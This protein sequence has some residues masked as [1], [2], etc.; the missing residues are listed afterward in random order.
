MGR[1]GGGGGRGCRVDGGGVGV[2]T[3]ML[4]ILML[5]Y[6]NTGLYFSLTFGYTTFN[7]KFFYIGQE[8]YRKEVKPG[9]SSY[10]YFSTFL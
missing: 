1:G 7:R 4:H 3:H 9:K 2:G 5:L 8:N 6:R 10:I